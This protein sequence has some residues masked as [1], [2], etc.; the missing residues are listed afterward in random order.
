[1]SR[2]VAGHD[3]GIV[4]DGVALPGFVEH[5]A[6]LLRATSAASP[7][8][9]DRSEVRRFHE[10]C[11]TRGISPVDVPDP[12][13][14]EGLA[15]RL[16]GALQSAAD[17][18]ICELWEAG[19]RDW[20]DLDA[21]LDARAAGVLPVRVRVLAAAG[22]AEE[23]MRSKVGDPWCDLAGVKFYADG[24]LGTRTCALSHS[25]CD[26]DGNSGLAFES[27]VSLARRV[28][29]FAESGWL[30]ATHAIGDR[31]IE[32]V[33]EA[34]EHVWGD[35]CAAAAPRIEHVQVLRQD[36]V[37]RMASLGI[38]ACIQPGFGSDDF[39]ESKLAL[40]DEWPLA[41]RWSA[42]IDAGVRIVCGS[43]YPIDALDPLSGLRKLVQNPF[44]PM[45]VEVAVDLMTD[46]VVGTVTVS[47]DPRAV[48]T[49]RLEEIEVLATSP[50]AA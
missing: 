38:V 34:Y 15:A 20:A 48:E 33:I 16:L 5:H 44:D 17:L 24:W 8:W 23:G 25:F 3:D 13:E 39:D 26:E 43:D 49:D 6:H 40:E 7:P 47:E 19:M 29:P 31:A 46:P 11:A 27:P 22:L 30:I 18:G 36:L 28:E 45:A 9:S 21:L 1:V 35:D 50:S 41:Y 32:T 37:E 2:T 12:S 10:R 4:P 14:P 42:L